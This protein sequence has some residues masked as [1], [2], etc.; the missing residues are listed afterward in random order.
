[1]TASR[2]DR[3][4]RGAA[5]DLRL[6]DVEARL[7]EATDVRDLRLDL[8][9]LF[10]HRAHVVEAPVAESVEV[11]GSEHHVDAATSRL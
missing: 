11:V 8:E 1:M 4:T 10:V 3:S 6:H 5:I 9:A 7:R 2:S